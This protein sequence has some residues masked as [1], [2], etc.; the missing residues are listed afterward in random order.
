ME[1]SL[2]PKY[3]KDEDQWAAG[4]LQTVQAWQARWQ[5]GSGDAALGKPVETPDVRITKTGAQIQA[6]HG[7]FDNNINVLTE[8]LQR[9][10]GGTL[11][12]PMEWL[13]Y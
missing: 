7:S 1:R 2:V 5:P 13:D 12:A 11:V 3:A 8:T 9:I 4:E 10:K 6:T